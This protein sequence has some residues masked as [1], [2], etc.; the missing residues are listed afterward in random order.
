MSAH[1]D[2]GGRGE[3]PTGDPIMTAKFRVPAPQPW[4]VTRPRLLA[5]L[6]DGVRGPLTVVTAPAGSGKTVLAAGWAGA[7]RWPGPLVWVSLDEQD[8]QPGVLWSYVIAGLGHAGVPVGPVGTPSRPDAVEKSMLTRLAAVLSEQPGPVALVLDNAQVLTCAAV[9]ES[10]DFLLCHAD[11][12]LRLVVLGR[13][14]PDLPLH[15][16]RLSGSVVEIHA[17]DLA[18]SVPETQ[19]LLAAHR[20]ALSEP[21]LRNLV[22]QTRG[23]AAGLRL[24][25]RSME[26]QGQNAVVPTDL[27]S[28]LGQYFV[29][30]VLD[31]QPAGVREFLLRTSVVDRM[32]PGLV[33]VLSGHRNAPRTL[34]MLAH[35]STFVEPS[36]PDPHTYEYHPIVRDLLRAQLGRE[37]PNKVPQL[38][39]RAAQWLAEEGKL[40]EAVAHA[41]AA[42]DWEYA[43]ALLVEDLAIA[44][45]IADPRAPGLPELFAHMPHDAHGPES[46]IVQAALT[47]SRF[48][49]DLCAK[50]LMRASE[51]VGLRPV[52]RQRQL[53]LVVALV[54]TVHA[55]MTG[56]VEGALSAAAGADEVIADI[57]AGTGGVPGDLR[58][59]LWLNKGQVLLRTGDLDAAGTALTRSVAVAEASGSQPMRLESLGQLS[60]VEVLRGRLK[61][62][63]ELGRRTGAAVDRP[64]P[65]TPWTPATDVSLAWV[66]MEEYDLHAARR[67]ADRAA[68]A[69]GWPDPVAAGL[70]AIVRARLLRARGDIP[71]AVAALDRARTDSPCGTTPAWLIERLAATDLV[72]RAASG[73][74]ELAAAAADS[75]RSALALAHG[76][77]VTGALDGAD[78]RLAEVLAQPR[79]DVDVQVDAWLLT[80]TCALLRGRTDPARAALRRALRLAEPETLRRPFVEAPLRLR[81]FLRQER[82][83]TEPHAW[84]GAS[85]TGAH[86]PRADAVPEG[87]APIVEPLTVK[88]TEVLRH[89]AALLSTEEIARK[90]FVSVNTVKTHIRGVLRKLAASRRN[91]AVR[92]AREI[93]LL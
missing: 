52:E 27:H 30:E 86:L 67:H 75:P 37:T 85:I 42:G 91:E 11:P 55:R 63:Y 12:Q 74:P 25:A 76:H 26:Q 43:A 20:I 79:L 57:Q 21:E 32:R 8:D 87:T 92:R 88:E 93:G 59:L 62:A 2:Q 89:L 71:G 18:F 68:A 5:R 73:T 90:M 66:R 14:E 23:W 31:A 7:G 29:A 19:A 48:D 83:L 65:V 38:H 58:A 36:P 13:T 54:E 22:R 82:D 84:L 1:T 51:S 35:T 56:D 77:L 4:V 69:H 70:L 3:T 64:V 61:R 24:A 41:A 46:A 44:P 6:S 78:R 50:H 80:A 60:L 47:L 39:R 40:A 28:D 33:A 72:L 10:I 16:Y 45:L 17:D 49:T 81:R 9:A 53:G 15:R 34:A